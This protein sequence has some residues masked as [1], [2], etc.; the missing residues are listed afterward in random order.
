MFLLTS[1]ASEVYYYFF[2]YVAMLS[3][4][5]LSLWRAACLHWLRFLTI[6]RT[7]LSLYNLPAEHIL[8]LLSFFT[9]TIII[10][11]VYVFITFPW[12]YPYSFLCGLP[13]AGMNSF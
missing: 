8:N 9:I 6:P 3:L 2:F 1:V 7:I 4:T 13:V 10:I 5:Q 11:L 12:G